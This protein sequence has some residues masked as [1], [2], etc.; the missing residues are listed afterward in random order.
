M[1]E[2]CFSLLLWS[3]LG[4]AQAQTW[5]HDFHQNINFTCPTDQILSRLESEHDNK[6]QDRRWYLQCTKPKLA[7]VTNCEWNGIGYVNDW[8]GFM[9]YQCSDD[10]VISGIMSVFDG[11]HKDRRYRFYCCDVA[12]SVA[13]SCAFTSYQ[14]DYNR[15]LDYEVPN[16]WAIKGVFSHHWNNPHEDRRFKFEICKLDSLQCERPDNDILE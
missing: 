3:V 5:Q 16:G 14:N 12:D 10:K 4:L 15:K 8:D 11:Y 9:L 1:L 7:S 6:H 13:H 2:F